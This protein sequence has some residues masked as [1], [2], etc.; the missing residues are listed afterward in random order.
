VGEAFDEDGGHRNN[1][2]LPVE[3][4]RKQ[5]PEFRRTAIPSAILFWILDSFNPKS[6]FNNP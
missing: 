3:K 4:F 5:N 1:L 6:A 2:E